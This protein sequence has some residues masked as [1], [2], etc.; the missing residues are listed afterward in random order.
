[1]DEAAEEEVDKWQRERRKRQMGQIKSRKC[2]MRRRKRWM[3][4]RKRWMRQRNTSQS[5]TLKKFSCMGTLVG[6]I[7][8]GGERWGCVMPCVNRRAEQIFL[9]VPINMK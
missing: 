7:T 1:M 9:L 3:R 4:W 2:L 5:C 6:F 8:G